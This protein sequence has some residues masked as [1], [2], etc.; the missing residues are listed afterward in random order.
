MPRFL[1]TKDNTFIQ[2]INSELINEIIETPII[3]Y[4]LVLEDEADDIYGEN[5][6]KKYKPG[7]QLNCIINRDEQATE[8]DEFGV[9]KSQNISFNINRDYIS[10]IGIYPEI[11]DIIEW[12]EF[13]YESDNV[14]ENQYLA[15]RTTYNHSI[16]IDAHL[17]NKSNLNIEERN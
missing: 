10:G 11:G 6:N 15:G 2:G 7:V 14:K 4:K 8:D 17:T 16:I 9:N 5:I 1:T 3:I 12:N 13:Y